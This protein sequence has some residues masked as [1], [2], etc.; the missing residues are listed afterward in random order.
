[1]GIYV[2]ILQPSSDLNDALD[3]LGRKVGPLY[4]KAWEAKK[5]YY[6]DKPFDLHIN[7]FAM[8][9]FDGNMKVFVVYDDRTHEPVGF[10]TGVVFRPMPYKASVFQ[11]QEWY[12][13]NQAIE[14]QLITHVIS[15]IRILGC[16]ELWVQ[17]YD[18]REI[19]PGRAWKDGGN[20]SIRRYTK[21]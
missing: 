17:S 10:L 4:A 18:G 19:N 20:F 7:M 6:D 16:D 1:M 5:K 21:V 14:D 11:I 13:T 8:L 2:D 15:A 12:T 9:W 3:S